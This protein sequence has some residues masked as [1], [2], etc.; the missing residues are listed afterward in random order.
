MAEGISFANVDTWK[1]GGSDKSALS[2]KQIVLMHI[3][4]CVV[5]GSVE[6]HGGYWQERYKDNI[7]QRYYVQ[8]AR[9]IF[10]NSTKML[11]CLLCGY[12]DKEMKDSDD[13][14][15]KDFENMQKTY[16]KTK[17]KADVK[18]TQ[19]E[20]VQLHLVLFEELIRLC[21]RLN[22]FEEESSEEEM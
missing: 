3:Q 10:N 12:F 14:S 5:N 21:K 6:W 9:E 4:R 2:F 15:K 20:T 18:K 17:E 8:N 7:T 1:G 11:R 19:L 13:K 22:F 16:A